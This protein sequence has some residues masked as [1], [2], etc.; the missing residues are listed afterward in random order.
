MLVTRIIIFF[1]QKFVAFFYSY[2]FLVAMMKNHN[3]HFDISGHCP[4][5][6]LPQEVNSIICKWVASIHS[7]L[8]AENLPQMELLL[9][10]LSIRARFFHVTTLFL[11]SFFLFFILFEWV[12]SHDC[13]PH[14]KISQ[15]S[16]FLMYHHLFPWENL[17]SIC[18]RITSNQIT[19]Y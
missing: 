6:E 5:D 14:L 3:F 1:F 9:W 12:N 19:L 4:H 11:A 15:S 8:P 2:F 10:T 17:F 13:L 7:K 16:H 18:I